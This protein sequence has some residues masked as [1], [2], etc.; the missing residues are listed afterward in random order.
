MFKAARR[1]LPASKCCGRYRM[2]RLLINSLPSPVVQELSIRASIRSRRFRMRSRIC[3][4]GLGGKKEVDAK[5]EYLDR[6]YVEA[7]VVPAAVYVGDRPMPT[8]NCPTIGLRTLLVGREGLSKPLVQHLMHVMFET[9]FTRRSSRSQSAAG[10]D[11]VCKFTMA[12]RRIWIAMHAFITNE[13]C[14]NLSGA[15]SLFGAAFSAGALSLYSYLRRRK[16]RRP[17]EYIA[18]IRSVDAMASQPAGD[19]CRIEVGRDGPRTRHAAGE[20]QGAV[21]SRLLQ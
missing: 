15:L 2:W 9:D 14:E 18:Q 17:D 1:V 7:A 21:D 8:E 3:L 20:A 19:H 16:I 6:S 12:R 4:S 11:G 5:G 10:G 13:F